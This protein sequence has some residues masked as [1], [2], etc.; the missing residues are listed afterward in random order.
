MPVIE[1]SIVINAPAERV[2]AIVDDPNRLP[3]YM[4]G[5]VRVADVVQ[6]PVRI[7]DSMRF[8]YAVIGLRFPGKATILDWEQNSRVVAKL[9]GGIGGTYTVT[10]RPQSNAT[11]ATW[12]FD[13]TMK[14]GILG[15]AV[16]ALLVE[17]INEKNAERGLENLKMLCEAT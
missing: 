12:R 13:Y 11:R 1:K 5:I 15:K 2:F 9:E 7:G 8:T 17:R 6:T 3:D 16:N 4:V 14:G 10:L